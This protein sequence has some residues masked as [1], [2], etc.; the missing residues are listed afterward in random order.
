MIFAHD[1]EVALNAA[2][3]LVNTARDDVGVPFEALPDTDALDEFAA[4]WGWTGSRTHDR[5][6]LAAVQALRPRLAEL[7]FAD[8]DRAVEIVNTLLREARALPQLTKHDE[9]DYHL[10]A[11]SPTSRWPTGWRSRRRWR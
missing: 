1:T 6:E 2:T 8:E 3:A 5:T 9:W 10:H 11:T 4:E 7:W